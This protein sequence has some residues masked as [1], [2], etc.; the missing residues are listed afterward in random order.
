MGV[1]YDTLYHSSCLEKKTP[2]PLG[3]RSHKKREG[4]K[5]YAP[6]S[7][8]DRMRVDKAS[9]RGKQKSWSILMWQFAVRGK[10][11]LE[12]GE[13]E[14]ENEESSNKTKPKGGRRGKKSFMHGLSIDHQGCQNGHGSCLRQ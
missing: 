9:T 6:R 11:Q 5:V 1:L 7:L 8:S 13:G 4:Q 10:L 12:V 3:E 2:P 14:G